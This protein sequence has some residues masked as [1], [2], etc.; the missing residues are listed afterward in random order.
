[1]INIDTGTIIAEAFNQ[2]LPAIIEISA[3]LL[4]LAAIAMTLIWWMGSVD[5]VKEQLLEKA[6]KEASE[7][8]EKAT[9]KAKSIKSE[10]AETAAKLKEETVFQAEKE[11]SGVA[12]RKQE[13]HEIMR[14]AEKQRLELETEYREKEAELLRK[15]QAWLDELAGVKADRDQLRERLAKILKGS[16]DH[17]EKEGN[18]GAANR[19]KKQLKNLQEEGAVE[20]HGQ[21]Q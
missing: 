13:A 10:A 11:I 14:Q 21:E 19:R 5:K 6:N 1:M 9:V 4:V 3:I 16:V 20:G 17:W 8:C 18:I 7:L 2:A 12:A 15:R